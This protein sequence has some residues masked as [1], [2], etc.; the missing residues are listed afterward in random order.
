MDA[1]TSVAAYFEELIE[2]CNRSGQGRPTALPQNDQYIFYVISTRCEMDINGFESVFD[3]L[4][5]ESEI[6]VLI[7]AFNE[8]GCTTLAEAFSTARSRLAGAGFFDDEEMMVID[9][10]TDEG[11][12]L[13]DIEETVR[14]SNLLWELDDSLAELL[15]D[16]A[17]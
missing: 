3:Q 7:N 10:A 13:D 2:R 17:K 14:N 15:P 6:S 16:E 1:P 11:G 8:L 4:L 9:L 5:E 12:F